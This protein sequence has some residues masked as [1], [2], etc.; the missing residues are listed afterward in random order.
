MSAELFNLYPL[1]STIVSRNGNDDGAFIVTMVTYLSIRNAHNY[2]YTDYLIRL[3][4]PVVRQRDDNGTTETVRRYQAEQILN[5]MIDYIALEILSDLNPRERALS[6]GL[7][8]SPG[9]LIGSGRQLM[10]QQAILIAQNLQAN[11]N[12]RV[13]S[14]QLQESLETGDPFGDSVTR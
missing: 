2:L 1:K 12:I 6:F 14:G 7:P 4:R 13:R 5:S 8:H 3:S 11:H 10:N 9:H